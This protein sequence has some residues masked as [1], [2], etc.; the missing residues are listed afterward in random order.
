MLILSCILERDALN[1][2][3]FYSALIPPSAGENSPAE[4]FTFPIL[5]SVQS[6]SKWGEEC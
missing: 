6:L 5:Y 3:L 1:D 2:F 4:D